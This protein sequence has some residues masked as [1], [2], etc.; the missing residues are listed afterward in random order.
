[1]HALHEAWPPAGLLCFI[2][3][4]T[5]LRLMGV[6]LFIVFFYCFKVVFWLPLPLPEVGKAYACR[7]WPACLSSVPFLY[8]TWNILCGQ[9]T[10]VLP[11]S[12]ASPCRWVQ[13]FF[14]NGRHGGRGL[15]ISQVPRPGVCDF[16]AHTPQ[17]ASPSCSAA[18]LRTLAWLTRP[19]FGGPAVWLMCLVFLAVPTFI[20]DCRG[21]YTH[22]DNYM[23][24]PSLLRRR[25]NERHSL[26]R[27]ISPWE[28]IKLRGKGRLLRDQY[29]FQ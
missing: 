21:T 2:H 25:T 7:G 4:G 24:A 16:F 29:G 23:R 11:R 19:A 28:D 20:L 9:K 17:T 8:S 1:M 13:S 14:L 27:R 10:L 3:N 15:W 6:Y 5:G 12:K 18:G 22:Q 26:F